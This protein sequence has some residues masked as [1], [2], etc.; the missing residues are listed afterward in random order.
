MLC[1]LPATH[2]LNSRTALP[3]FPIHLRITSTL[4]FVRT[5]WR[6]CV[7]L[8]ITDEFSRSSTVPRRSQI[9]YTSY[10]ATRR[11]SHSTFKT[12]ST[13]SRLSPN[14][15]TSRTLAIMSGPTS[16]RALA[17]CSSCS[18]MARIWPRCDGGGGVYVIAWRVRRAVRAMMNHPRLYCVQIKAKSR[19][20]GRPGCA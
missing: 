11:K 14:S 8:P 12:T 15:N 10:T 19:G 5:R 1:Q 16:A 7:R 17:I 6:C 2:N 18:L 9:P 3:G 20:A 13:S 4:G